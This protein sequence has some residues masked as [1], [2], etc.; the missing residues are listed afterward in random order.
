MQLENSKLAQLAQITDIVADTGDFDTIERL[1]P[2]DATTNPSLL[3]KLARSDSGNNL[4]N[5]AHQ[6]AVSIEKQPSPSLLCDAFAA[7]TGEK[8]S[9]RINGLV[10]TEVDARLSFDAPAMLARARRLHLL[11]RELGVN[12]DRVLIKLAASW[13]GIRAAETLETEGIQCNMTLLFNLT[14]AIAA[15]NANVTLIS[16]FV[17]RIYDWH[18]THGSTITGADDDPGVQSVRDIFHQY[19]KRGVETIIMGASFRN[20]GQIEALAGCDKLTISP[21]LLEQLGSDSGSLPK[22]L[23]QSLDPDATPFAMSQSE[24][25]LQMANDP[26]ATEL[27]AGGIRRF[28]VDQEALEACFETI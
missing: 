20:A 5:E 24:F 27:L 11:Y 21:A 12:H 22:A 13:Q 28:I 7:L 10:S 25:L 17:G 18:L 1:Q 3:L 19:K 4:L 14:Q 9:K 15:A 8:I 6:L 26:M 2:L 23:S 16:P